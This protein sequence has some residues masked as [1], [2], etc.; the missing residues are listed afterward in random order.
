MRRDAA[1]DPMTFAGVA[2]V[3]FTEYCDPPRERR[4]KAARLS[5][6]E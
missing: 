6:D 3:L 1:R 5:L 2:I 4:R